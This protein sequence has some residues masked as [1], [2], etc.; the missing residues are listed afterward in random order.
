MPWRSIVWAGILGILAARAVVARAAEQAWVVDIGSP[1]DEECL[2]EGFYQ[3]EGPN[4]QSKLAMAAKG[5]FRWAKSRF[6]LRL[7]VAPGRHNQITL[8][9]QW[10]GALK[11]SVGD[12]W[13]AVLF[14]QGASRSEYQLTVPANV[15]GQRERLTIEA[16]GR[17]VGPGTRDKR[18][19]FLMLDR[20]EVRP[21]DTLRAAEGE[22]PP[23]LPGPAAVRDRV[24]GVEH[25]PPSDDPEQFA[26]ALQAQQANVV[27]LGTMNGQGR[28]FFATDLAEPHPAMQPGYL[29]QVIAELRRRDIRILDWVVF[30]AQDL[31]KVEDFAPAR[32]FPQWQ[33]Q[34]I[35]EPGKSWKAR[36][37]MCLISSPYV[38][39]HANLLRETARFD[40]D[41]FFFDGFYLGGIPHPARPGCVCEFCRAAFKQ[42]T[43]LDLPAR[44]DWL[45]MTFKRWVR[46]R[47]ERLLRTA[48]YFSDAIHQVNPQASCTFNTN[49]WPFGNKDWETAIPMWR[50]D[51][52]GVSQHGYSSRFHEKWMMLGFKARIGRDMN[53]RHTDMWRAASLKTT[54]G[55]KLQDWAWHELEI[56]T[57]LLAAISHGITP[58]HSTIEGAPELAARIHAEAAQRE[59]YFSRLH[60]ADVAVLCSQ[61]THDFFGHLPE[62]ENLADFRDGILGTWMLLSQRH[63]PFEFLFDNQL[64]A[65]SLGRY[66]T[67]ILAN[68]AALSAAALQAIDAWVRRGGHLITTAQTGRFDEWGRALPVSHLAACWKLDPG[69]AA[70][71]SVGQGL[72]THL[73]GDPGLAWCRD[74]DAN[75]AES[76]LKAIGHR[77]LSLEV[78]GPSWLVT[79]VFLNPANAR[80]HW[81][82]LLNVS[83]LMPHGDAGFRGM[84]R[85]PAVA[86]ETGSDADTGAAGATVGGPLLPARDVVLRLRDVRPTAARLAIAGKELSADAEGRI[87]LPELGLHDVLIVSQ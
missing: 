46:W 67:L 8:I 63:V 52:L 9:A 18:E 79:N 26:M 6:T 51:D 4:A 17:T 75:A 31:R 70:E 74:R 58:W 21:I 36:V 60:V 68:T 41:G 47:N 49:L 29:P 13:H 85:Q 55:A 80:E 25:R 77:P 10:R 54:C 76:L 78:Q 43:G 44:V 56:K 15:V 87:R 23:L 2:G 12:A 7:P 37:G 39:H 40:L 27:T 20:V 5:T 84:N 62:S 28:V 69:K 83:H 48:R 50:I 34:Y 3:R 71:L 86:G 22:L 14:G 65:R 19:L 11:I 16:Q 57:F 61:N 66:R 24:R 72:V 30:N 59:P 53:P 32:R 82:H 45:D 35:D 33:M 38:E 81:V 64:D 73:P 1:G 42:D